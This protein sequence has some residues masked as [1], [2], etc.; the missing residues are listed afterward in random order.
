MNIEDILT[1]TDIAFLANKS[2]GTIGAL[3]AK[4]YLPDPDGVIAGQPVWH[5][6]TV[7]AWL[8]SRPG[9]GGR[10]GH[11]PQGSEEARAAC[12]G[13]VSAPELADRFGVP[14]PTF[15]DWVKAGKFPSP[16]GKV[17]RAVVWRDEGLGGNF[18]AE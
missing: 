5:R 16:D 17:G 12:A 8:A 2:R 9:Y 7:D 10:L 15:R 3:K 11:V 14:A 1:M 18:G 6:S 13:W 4:G